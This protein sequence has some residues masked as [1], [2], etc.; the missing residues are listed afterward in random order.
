M[1]IKAIVHLKVK[2]GAK[3]LDT[4]NKFLESFLCK[5]FHLRYTSAVHESHFLVYNMSIM[6][7]AG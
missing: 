3:R 1:T 5:D 6:V 2:R 4:L 7:L